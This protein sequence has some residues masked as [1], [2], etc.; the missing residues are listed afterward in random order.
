MFVI[1]AKELRHFDSI[2]FVIEE[3]RHLANGDT[4][5][6]DCI[7]LIRYFAMNTIATL[8][9]ACS[10]FDYVADFLLSK[11]VFSVL[12]ASIASIFLAFDVLFRV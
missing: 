9:I 2:H 6:C 12:K 8:C 4:T 10:D 1:P 3:C 7:Y 5:K 11:M